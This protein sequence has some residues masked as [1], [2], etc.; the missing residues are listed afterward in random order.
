MHVEKLFPKKKLPFGLKMYCSK[1]KLEKYKL[2][3][4]SVVACL[5]LI[6]Y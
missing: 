4:R 5:L 2:E 3:M 6:V 1:N